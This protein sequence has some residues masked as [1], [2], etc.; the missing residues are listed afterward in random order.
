M[1][2]RTVFGLVLWAMSLGLI[3][4]GL[5]SANA[6]GGL[7]VTDLAHGGSAS[8]LVTAIVGSG[9]S[10]SNITYTG[11]NVAAGSFSGGATIIG[12]D[13]GIVLGSGSVQTTDASSSCAKGVEGPN[14]CDGN[15]TENGTAGDTTLSALAGSTQNPPVSSLDTN[16][17]AVL[18]FD[19]TPAGS[20]LTFNYV[21]TS[22]EYNEW[23]NSEFNDVFGF[24]V[25]GQNCA[26]VPG[27]STPVT[28]N[29]VNG[30][31][32]FGTS[33][34]N[35]AM[36]RNNDPDDPGPPGI[37]TE[38]D[39]LT[40]VFTCT[41]TV[42]P[43]VSNHIKIAIADT[44]DSRLDSNVFIQAG[45]FSAPPTTTTTTTS[46]TSPTTTTT[47]TEPPT[48]TTSTTT[49]STTTTSTTTTSTT[50]TTTTSTTTTSTT[51]PSTTTTS[52]TVPTTTTTAACEAA[53]PDRPG[54]GYGDKNHCHTGPPG[55]GGDGPKVK[56]IANRTDPS[57]RYGALALGLALAVVAL[58]VTAPPRRRRDSSA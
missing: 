4:F 49:T 2:R 42:N 27:T 10:T 19:F 13:A 54:N 34:T 57:D 32:P 44:S 55:N 3:V 9:I 16:D 48:T 5:G 53:K 40:T 58:G 41:A 12:F 22:D 35:A 6:I 50:S 25:N 23:V 7:V 31:N 11:A 20:Q 56:A 38:M 1:R 52:T 33:A 15:T 37:D 30:G 18:E 8:S 46:T 43:G 36:Y 17:A 21:F 39:G 29:S 14:E 26:L 45:S 24:F 51:A 28:I 47:T